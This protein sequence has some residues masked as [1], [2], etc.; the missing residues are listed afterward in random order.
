MHFSHDIFVVYYCHEF[1]L[2]NNNSKGELWWLAVDGYE[3]SK[4]LKIF[5]FSFWY[6]SQVAAIVDEST[7]NLQFSNC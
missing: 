2:H 6:F 7:I 1:L 3:Q 4:G 5:M